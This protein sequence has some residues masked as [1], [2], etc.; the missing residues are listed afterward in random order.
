MSYRLTLSAEAAAAKAG[1]STASAYRIEADPRLPSQKQAPRGR[2]RPD[3]LAAYWD[4]EIEPILKAAP[5]IRAVG[6]LE[7][8]RR[9]HPDL[10]PNI[11]RTLERRITAW[12]AF[13]GPERDV[14]FRQEHEPGRLGLSDFT[15]AGVLGITIAGASLDHRLYHFR[16]AFSGF[17]HAHVVLGGESFVALAEGLQNALWALGGVPREHRSDSLSAAFR[18]L[19]IDAR[20]DITQRYE[21]L[22]QHYGMVAT[23][24]NAGIAHENG[25]IESAHGHLKQALEDALLLRGTRDF[26]DLDAYRAF[27]DMVVG[28]RNAHVVKRI[29]IEKE[30]LAPLP[31][32]R[33]SDFEEKVIRVTSSGGFILRRV[34]YTM[35][36]KLI[37][38]RLR[39]RIFDDRLECFLGTTQVA[40][41]RRGQP[42]S[43]SRGGHVVD[44]RH[45]IHALRRKPMALANL[46]Y[47]DQLFPRA[48]YRRAFETLQD[49]YDERHA[50]KV[51]VEPLA[52]AHERACEAELAEA[53]AADLDAGRL[54]DLATL[55]IRFR[56]EQASVPDVAVELAPLAAYDELASLGFAPMTSN[57]GDAA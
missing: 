51:T 1:F 53:I 38:H 52:L 30:M 26:A 33:T 21:Q 41:L 57:T 46:V 39:V 2:R 13:N 17:A 9:R 29:A 45:V 37:G 18:N 36:S 11:R 40:M 43:E 54:P 12:R 4:A 50:C 5:G 49:R 31:R 14:I 7:E 32:G 16:L 3:P 25:S 48:A 24:N 35:P 8:L 23:R 19:A 27:V 10:N 20:E 42:V 6:V 28:R 15:D 56:P 44:Y 22:M 47:R 55:R 34:F